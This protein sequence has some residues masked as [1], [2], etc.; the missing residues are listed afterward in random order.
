M[1]EYKLTDSGIEIYVPQCY[2]M[3]VI[4]DLMTTA[5]EGGINY[6]CCKAEVIESDYYG[7]YASDQISRGGSLRLYDAETDDTW[8]LNLDKLVHGI[9][10]A[11]QEGYVLS[12]L[13][14]AD[15]ADADAIVQCGLFDDIVF[16]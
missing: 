16:G 15:A 7:E 10:R 2:A 14:D 6:W 4:D 9:I 12:D 13:E 5:L 3:Q 11:G 1:R 8:V